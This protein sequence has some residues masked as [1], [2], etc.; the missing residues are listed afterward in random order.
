MYR[1]LYGFV[2]S[3]EPVSAEEVARDYLALAEANG[4]A[5]KLVERVIPADSGLWWEDGY[6][7]TIDP[8]SLPLYETP[9]VV[10]D[11]ETTGSSAKEGGITELGAVKVWRGEILDEL[12]TLVN[13]GLPI[14]PFV[15]KL[16]GITDEMVAEAPT[17]A[18]VM[19]RFE[20]FAEGCVLV[21]H[22]VSFDQGFV[23]AARVSRGM[24]P[25]QNPI[26]DTL[27]L[28]RVLVP[29]LE[30]YRLSS[31]VEY[32]DIEASP[33]HRALADAEATAGILDKLLKLL[34]S[35]GIKSAGE[36]STL[37]RAS[38][39]R[40]KPQKQH[41]AEGV[42][43]TPGVYYFVNKDGTVLY[44]GKA[45]NLKN[46]VRTYFAGGD[47]RRKVG[48]LVRETAEVR[49][50]ETDSE[51]YALILEARE[52]RRL[53]PR[54]NAVGRSEEKSWFIKLSLE[55]PYP[56]PERVAADD[57]SPG[58]AVFVGPY[59]STRMLGVCIEALGRIFP[60]RRC[61]GHNVARNGPCFYGQMGRCAPCL[62]MSEEE[63]RRT[64]VDGI[65][66]LLRGEGGEDHLRAL[67]AERERLA[68]ELEFEA[69]ARLRDLISG[70]ERARLARAIVSSGGPQA[71]VAPSTEPGVMEVFVISCGRLISHRGF[72][73]GDEAGLSEFASESL[74]GRGGIPGESAGADEARV[75]SSYLRRSRSATV[76]E[77][78][79][80]DSPDDLL[81]TVRKVREASGNSGDVEEDARDGVEKAT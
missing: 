8:A 44:V 1:S 76:V 64:V 47:G 11:V 71:V 50:E 7:R 61:S 48:R 52:I 54:F 78:V 59:R 37:R 56:V 45:K 32:F 58:E 53:L 22:N 9:Y 80:L 74:A 72:E 12:S 13:P 5:R 18:E 66:T 41:L 30:R 2:K 19:T 21:G 67:V 14:Q 69:A 33:N 73:E 27:K 31:L 79:A 42:P 65:V 6:L 23:D 17:P 75:V 29:G 26:L 16:T 3:R 25:L 38:K 28:A 51:L 62:N 10:F 43:D 57:G 49:Y 36:A 15:V 35:Q 40:S 81:R 68:G 34:D 55:E 46:R 20:E 4:D 39:K 60:I 24:M 63:Y 70:I 77:A